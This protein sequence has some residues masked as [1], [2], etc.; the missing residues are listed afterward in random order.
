M[1]LTSFDLAEQVEMVKEKKRESS[2]L[3]CQLTP[4]QETARLI[5]DFVTLELSK[6]I[7]DAGQLAF[8]LLTGVAKS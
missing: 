6:D 2:K 5:N 4:S 7:Y 3:L 8:S 1:K